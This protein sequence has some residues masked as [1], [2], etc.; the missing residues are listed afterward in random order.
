[1]S[2]WVTFFIWPKMFTMD[3]KHPKRAKLGL[4]DPP[5]FS[6]LYEKCTI[7]FDPY[8]FLLIIS[9]LVFVKINITNWYFFI[10]T[11]MQLYK[12]FFFFFRKRKIMDWVTMK[13]EIQGKN[14]GFCGCSCHRFWCRYWYCTSH[15]VSLVKA[16][17]LF[18]GCCHQSRWSLQE[19]ALGIWNQVVEWTG[20][21]SYTTEVY[22]V[23]SL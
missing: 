18:T 14:D 2:K 8:P 21:R 6:A 3:V 22:T 13:K 5:C 12:T 9:I 11:Y 4:I 19:S 10:V 15:W 17:G 20:G 16:E 23:Q 1:M 7:N